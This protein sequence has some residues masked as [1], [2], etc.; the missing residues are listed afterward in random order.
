E[1]GVRTV[2]R[3]GHDLWGRFAR[4][5]PGFVW[6]PEA[7][8][9]VS[10]AGAREAVREALAVEQRAVATA[11]IPDFPATAVP[12]HDGV[13]T[14][15]VGLVNLQVAARRTP[16]EVVRLKDDRVPVDESAQCRETGK[17]GFLQNRL[18]SHRANHE[19]AGPVLSD[20]ILARWPRARLGPATSQR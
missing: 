19:R 11:E 4:E 5:Q 18:R 20:P 1:Q 14:G 8:P 2:D 12:A 15:D 13:F 7:Y 9:G 17:V 6:M 16:H 3:H 10:L